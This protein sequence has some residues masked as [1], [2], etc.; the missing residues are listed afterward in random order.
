L[1]FIYF[2]RHILNDTDFTEHVKALGYF[3]TQLL[4]ILIRYINLFPKNKDPQTI[5]LKN[6]VG[7]PCRKYLLTW[8]KFWEIMTIMNQQA[9]VIDIKTKQYHVI[10]GTKLQC[11]R[12]DAPEGASVTF[13]VIGF[14]GDFKATGQAKATVVKH[15]LGEKRVVM[16]KTKRGH[17][18]HR[19]GS[20]PRMTLLR[21]DS[22]N[23]EVIK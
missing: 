2:H 20:R 22:V 17:D 13:P 19:T 15:Y 8:Q 10:D 5:N 21:I 23:K 14:F 18:R 9:A 7:R 11:D 16:Y 12:I 3:F 4:Y 6:G 1:I